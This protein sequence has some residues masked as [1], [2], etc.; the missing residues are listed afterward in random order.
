MLGFVLILS[1]KSIKLSSLPPVMSQE[2]VKKYFLVNI[3]DTLL[4]LVYFLNNLI[5]FSN[6]K[7]HNCHLGMVIHTI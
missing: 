2:F 3:S 1:E 7:L 5:R 4:L 6:R